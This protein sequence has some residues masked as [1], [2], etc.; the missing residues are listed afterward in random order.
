MGQRYLV[1]P[2]TVALTHSCPV[3]IELLGRQFLVDGILMIDN[4]SGFTVQ[5]A[6]GCNGVEAMVLLIAAIAAFPGPWHYKLEK[7][8]LGLISTQLSILFA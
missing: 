4:A 7:P 5:I 2:L 1:A 3:I 8:I 6:A